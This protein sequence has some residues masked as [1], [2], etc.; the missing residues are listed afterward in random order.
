MAVRTRVGSGALSLRLCSAIDNVVLQLS[1][2]LSLPVWIIEKETTACS[3]RTLRRRR[4]ARINGSHTSERRSS[5]GPR[6]S[7]VGFK[8]FAGGSQT[9]GPSNST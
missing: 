8:F 1:W 6:L 4:N 3:R 5:Q 7:G 2:D 9:A